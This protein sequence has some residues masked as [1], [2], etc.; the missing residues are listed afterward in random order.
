MACWRSRIWPVAAAD[1]AFLAAF[2]AAPSD[3]MAASASR[4][5]ASSASSRVVGWV[6]N[7]CLQM[8]P[9]GKE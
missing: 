6:I 8:Q 1:L 7:V 4:S 5:T 3:L 9:Q 2:K